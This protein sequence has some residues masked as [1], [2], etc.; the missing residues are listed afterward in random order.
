MVDVNIIICS[1]WDIS[2]LEEAYPPGTVSVAMVDVNMFR[3][4]VSWKGRIHQMACGYG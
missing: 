1:S 3:V 4:L 2:F